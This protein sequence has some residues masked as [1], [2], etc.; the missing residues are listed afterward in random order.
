MHHSCAAYISSLSSSGLGDI[1]THTCSDQI[2]TSTCTLV[3]PYAA[4]WL[5]VVP[6][7]GLGLHLEPNELQVQLGRRKW[8]GG[9]GGGG[10]INH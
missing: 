2:T 7:E 8:V 6:S 4:S 5:T 3:S 1:E 10:G 9:G